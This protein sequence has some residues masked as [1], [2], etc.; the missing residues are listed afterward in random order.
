MRSRNQGTIIIDCD[1]CGTTG[2]VSDEQLAWI[3]RGK[4]FRDAR[5]ESGLTMRD[6]ARNKGID[7]Y[8]LSQAERGA[9]EPSILEAL[10][11]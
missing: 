11:D 9:I 5:V 8:V 1:V 4:E 6:F 7:V 2:I 3:K 10:K